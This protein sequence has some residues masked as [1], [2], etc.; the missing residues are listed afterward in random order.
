MNS[1]S[2]VHVLPHESKTPSA[3]WQRTNVVATIEEINQTIE[4]GWAS[5]LRVESIK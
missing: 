2:D 4:D 5:K 1:E 3:C